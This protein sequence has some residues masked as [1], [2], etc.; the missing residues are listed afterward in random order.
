[1]ER[2]KFSPGSLL[3]AASCA[4]LI[5]SADWASLPASERLTESAKGG[6]PRFSSPVRSGQRSPAKLSFVKVR[7]YPAFQAA[8]IKRAALAGYFAT[9]FE[10]RQGRDAADIESGSELLLALGVQ[11]G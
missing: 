7:S 4:S 1:M 9:L 11:F 6:R 8:E 10:D 3:T 5:E 2:I